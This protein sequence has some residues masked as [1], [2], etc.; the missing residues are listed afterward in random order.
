MSQPTMC[1]SICVVTLACVEVSG[2]GTE[3]NGELC[4]GEWGVGVSGG[5][6]VSKEYVPTHTP[7]CVHHVYA[8]L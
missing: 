4:R 6:E 3:M 7:V 2:R 1:Y 5:V 8:W